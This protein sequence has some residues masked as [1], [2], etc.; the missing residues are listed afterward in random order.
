MCTF[1]CPHVERKRACKHVTW[2]AAVHQAD[3]CV[4]AF[5]VLLVM[6][7]GVLEILSEVMVK[8]I[9]RVIMNS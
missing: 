3:G 4:R 8:E 7:S 6:P 5:F 1:L 9:R 2:N